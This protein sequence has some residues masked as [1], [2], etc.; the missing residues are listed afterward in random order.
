M[1]FMLLSSYL[2][3]YYFSA[4]FK[5]PRLICSPISSK[6]VSPG[7]GLYIQIGYHPETEF[8]HIPKEEKY[9]SPLWTKGNCLPMM[10]KYIYVTVNVLFRIS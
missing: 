6:G 9:L 10:G 1:L 5:H 3:P 2:F 4:Y 7:R 8:L